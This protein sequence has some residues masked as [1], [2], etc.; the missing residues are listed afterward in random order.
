MYINRIGYI[1]LCYSHLLSWILF[2]VVPSDGSCALERYAT[3][4]YQVTAAQTQ[5]L[6]LALP[7]YCSYSILEDIEHKRDLTQLMFHLETKGAASRRTVVLRDRDSEG[8][9]SYVYL[10]YSTPDKIE[11]IQL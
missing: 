4:R 6:D 1:R 3:R 2:E 9:R 5:K 7:L 11:I 10:L 8:R